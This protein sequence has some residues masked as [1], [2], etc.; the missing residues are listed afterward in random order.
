MTRTQKGDHRPP[1]F[2][3]A[4]DFYRPA[5]MDEMMPVAMPISM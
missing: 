1:F 2:I 3:L 4:E 5:T